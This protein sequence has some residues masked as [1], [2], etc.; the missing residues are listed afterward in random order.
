MFSQFSLQLPRRW[1]EPMEV[2]DHHY[3]RL[4]PRRPQNPFAQHLKQPLPPL[5][6]CKVYLSVALTN[7]ELQEIG[8]QRC[9]LSRL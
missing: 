9:G 7:G 8:D 3:H 6:G 5:I 4:Q 1:I 2:L